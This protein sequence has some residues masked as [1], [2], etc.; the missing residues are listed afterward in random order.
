VKEFLWDALNVGKI[1]LGSIVVT[2]LVLLG[3]WGVFELGRWTVRA[4]G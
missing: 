1:L 4:F 2:G 3:L